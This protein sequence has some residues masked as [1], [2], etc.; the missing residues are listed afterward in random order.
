MNIIG[1]CGQAGAGKDTIAD[2]LVK[3][4]KFVKLSFADPLKRICHDVFDFS[5]SSSGV[6]R[7]RGTRRTSD[8]R[9]PPL[10]RRRSRSS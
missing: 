6:R 2:F 9:A 4:H 3:D 7:R 5:G 1:V 8:T 10:A